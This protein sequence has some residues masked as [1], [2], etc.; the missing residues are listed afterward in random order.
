MDDPDRSDG[1]VESAD[2]VIELLQRISST[3]VTVAEIHDRE[4][5]A[6][7]ALEAFLQC[8]AQRLADDV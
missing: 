2:K 4:Q 1:V 3:P 7:A 8:A 5:E 6:A